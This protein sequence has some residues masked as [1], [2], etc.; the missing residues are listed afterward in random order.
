MLL[1][2]S[3]F[4]CLATVENKIL[5]GLLLNICLTTDPFLDT[6]YNQYR[7]SRILYLTLVD[8]NPS[9]YVFIRYAT[10]QINHI[11]TV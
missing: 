7:D 1:K 10:F 6:R 3:M 2:L 8:Q 4:N 5:R 9:N 11:M